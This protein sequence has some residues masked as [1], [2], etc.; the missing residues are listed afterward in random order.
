MR[1]TAKLRHQTWHAINPICYYRQVINHK[2][3]LLQFTIPICPC[4]QHSSTLGTDHSL[5]KPL[6]SK[7]T[8][9]VHA[10]FLHWNWKRYLLKMWSGCRV[11]LTTESQTVVCDAPADTGFEC[12]DIHVFYV[13][14][15]LHTSL[16]T[17]KIKWPKP[18][19]NVI[20]GSIVHQH[21]T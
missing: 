5:T 9:S 3:D 18:E 12:T 19:H 17:N 6:W 2:L 7:C 21:T 8:V 11:D 4:Q 10:I 13:P 20:P 14:F 1:C 15:S 16:T